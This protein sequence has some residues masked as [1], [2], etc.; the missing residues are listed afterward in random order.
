MK[1]RK[2]AHLVFA[3]AALLFRCVLALAAAQNLPPLRDLPLPEA[4]VIGSDDEAEGNLWMRW[5]GDH[6]LGYVQGYLTGA[7]WGYFSACTKVQIAAPSLPALRETCM[8]Q[9]PAASLTSERYMEL[10]TKFYSKYPQDRALPI[11]RVLLKLLEPGMTVDGIH[12]WLDEMIE[13]QEH[14]QGK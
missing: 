6:R 8:S 11:R 4:R 5:S 3:S 7:F 12:K 10:V 2:F 9:I 14:P 1:N 13:H